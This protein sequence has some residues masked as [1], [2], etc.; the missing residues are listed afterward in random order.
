[1]VV[2]PGYRKGKEFYFSEL[3]ITGPKQL[4]R[5]EL[6][7]LDGDGRSEILVQ[8]HVGG[9]ESHREVLLAFKVDPKEAPT[10]VFAHEVA[11]VTDEGSI[12][13]KVQIRNGSITIAQGKMEGFDP[14]TYQEPLPGKGVA[15]AL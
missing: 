4:T 7:D 2:G 10:V 15:S 14:G 1:S 12:R 13:N 5:L 9:S 11:I 3:N 6:E 8:K